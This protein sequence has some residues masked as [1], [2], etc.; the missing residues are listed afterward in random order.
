[1]FLL[2][3]QSFSSGLFP[4]LGYAAMNV[5]PTLLGIYEKFFVPLGDKLRPALSGF[6][7]G[8]I[9]G[10]EC[11]LDHFERTNSLLN[12]V[13]A[14]VSP[15]FFYTCLW[16]C[17][18]TNASIRLPAISYL[19]D[20]FNRKLGM[21]DQLSLMGRNHDVLMAGLCACLNDPVILVQ[22]NT[23]EFL[24]IGFP[25]HTTLLSVADFTRLVT[26][27]LNTI[28]RR[29]MSLNRR[30]YAWLL[31]SEVVGQRAKEQQQRGGGGGNASET[32]ER[33]A[34]VASYFEQHSKSVLIRA[35]RCTLKQSLQ[36]RPVDLTP[37]KILVSLLDKVEIGPVVLDHV[38][39]DVV[40]TMACARGNDDVIKSANLL[41]ATFDPAYIWNFMT[42]TYGRAC[43][44]DRR[45]HRRR[46]S[47]GQQQ[48]QQLQQQQQ[49]VA[50]EVDSG[51]P[52]LIEVCQLT[53][54]L[55]ESISLEMYHETT[56]LYLPRVFLAIV[57]ML[58]ACSEHLDADEVTASLK[59]CMKIVS[60]VQPMIQSPAK[61]RSR[62]PVSDGAAMRSGKDGEDGGTA[63]G[64]VGAAV[65]DG[66]DG[67]AGGSLEKS[68]S[69]SK[70]NQVSV[71]F[72][73]WFG[74][75]S[76]RWDFDG[77]CWCRSRRWSRWTN[78]QTSMPNA[79]F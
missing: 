45:Q 22:R 37:Y 17:I 28:L 15:H 66:A 53:E 58:T 70:I 77:G 44:P 69:D 11:G 1:M 24:L 52:C 16:E 54:F 32:L 36:P 48:Q 59:L 73:G 42:V 43:Q 39:C 61:V 40:R 19:L 26:N 10:Y 46:S 30:L 7:S 34:R 18:S 76:I 23:L 56:R 14:A 31:G 49:P 65:G 8:V 25:M 71:L 62:R 33:A 13:C 5:R 29:D 64:G 68:K 78:R 74:A 20:H 12:Q 72:S 2:L 27:G 67:G 75:V 51:E 6:L 3:F 55:L 63:A 35:L 47:A 57:Q 79:L 41:F 60:R 21:Q 38:L 50:V 4:L 9:P